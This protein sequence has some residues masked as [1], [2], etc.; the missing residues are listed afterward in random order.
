MEQHTK[1]RAVCPACKGHGGWRDELC[2]RCD[3]S[4]RIEVEV[5]V[6]SDEQLREDAEQITVA[7]LELEE[8]TMKELEDRDA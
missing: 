1:E 5:R 7:F 6:A 3:S 8:Q 4:G 2:P